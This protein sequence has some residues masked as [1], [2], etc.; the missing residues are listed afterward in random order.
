MR[1][2]N[3][4]HLL[5]PLFPFVGCEP[6]YEEL[7]LFSCTAAFIRFLGCEPTYEELK[8][9]NAYGEPA[10]TQT[11]RAYLWGI[12][13]F[14]FHSK[15]RRNKWRCEPTY[16][17]LK[18]RKVTLAKESDAWVASLPMRNWNDSVLPEIVLDTNFGCEPTYEELKPFS[19]SS[20]WSFSWVASLPMR[21]WNH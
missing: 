4:F 13:T 18:H 5:K 14:W 6:T 2:W 12:E 10:S 9:N 19:F 15:S 7:K 3:P 20:F 16:E 8:L 11:L 21:N 1:N 17:E